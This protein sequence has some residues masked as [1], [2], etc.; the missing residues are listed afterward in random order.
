MSAMQKAGTM[1]GKRC[2]VA[3]L[4]P[5]AAEAV[6]A[7]L[8]GAGIEAEPLP[9][10]DGRTRGLGLSHTDDD[11]CYPAVLLTGDFVNIARRP[12][13]QPDRSVFF[14]P[15]AD[16]PCRLGQYGPALARALEAQGCGAVQ[17]LT[18]S[19]RNGF[20]DLGGLADDFRRQLWRAVVATDLLHAALL[21]T[22]PYELE[23]G[24]AVQAFDA[25]LADL[26]AAIRDSG[27][28]RPAM[29]RAARRFHEVAVGLEERPRIGLVGEVYCRLNTYA[30][31]GLTRE[32][33]RQGA[34]VILSGTVELLDYGAEMELQAL[35]VTGRRWSVDMLRTL[36]R[37]SVKRSDRKALE[38]A[39]GAEPEPET[40]ELLALAQPYLPGTSVVGEMVMSLGKAAWLARHGASGV[41]D[42]SP[43]GCM[44]GVVSQAIYPRLSRDH[45]GIPIRNLYFDGT[46][47]DLEC[48]VGAFLE[49]AR[50]YR[51]RRS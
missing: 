12:G 49:V 46:H 20:T 50:V 30:N 37:V 9:R 45:G 51:R 23:A 11:I 4:G 44:N 10:S 28:L 1:A 32:L 18:P 15:S 16:G 48:E 26:C 6:C 34:E 29:Q 22:R 7:C 27:D 5:G 14:L 3:P 38:R 21:R 35:R 33:E 2:Y 40:Q 43:F 47:M 13:F 41:V 36:A 25:S 42:A 39:F 31:N 8:A 24:A 19:D 17:L